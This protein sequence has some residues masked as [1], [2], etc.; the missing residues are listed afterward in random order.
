MAF[1]ATNHTSRA[2]AYLSKSFH[3]DV[4]FW[5]S[6]C[7]DMESQTTYL[8]EIVQ[9]LATDMGYTDALGLGCEGV[10]IDPKKDG[11][12]YAWRLPFPEDI[13]ADLVSSNNT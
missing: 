2:T 3:R 10:W 12:Q 11:V 9:H 13:M 5:Q 7:A 8:A 1:T 6:L 4:K